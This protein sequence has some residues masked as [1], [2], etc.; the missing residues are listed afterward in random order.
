MTGGVAEL[1]DPKSH[2]FLNG[3]ILSLRQGTASYT[4]FVYI[5]DYDYLVFPNPS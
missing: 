2:V 5:Y 3:E 1:E 4:C